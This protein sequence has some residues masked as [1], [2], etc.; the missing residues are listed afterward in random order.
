[1]AD[2]LTR[3]FSDADKRINKHYNEKGY[4][5]NK[6]REDNPEKHLN[7]TSLKRLIKRFEAFDTTEKQK[8]SG[9]PRTATTPENEEAAEEMFSRRSSRDSCALKRYCRGIKD[10]TIFCTEND[11]EKRN[12]TIQT[13]QSILN[14]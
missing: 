9:C 1:M 10:L 2:T 3:A 14:E 13:S 6:T 8:G 4:T 7:K 12:E 11:Q 5:A